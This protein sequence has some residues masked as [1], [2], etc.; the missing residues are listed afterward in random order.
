M[1]SHEKN[2]DPK[3]LPEEGVQFSIRIVIPSG[4][5]PIYFRMF[6]LQYLFPSLS[7]FFFNFCIPGKM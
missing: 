5:K 7:L 4:G 1:V 3:K 6:Y 2:W